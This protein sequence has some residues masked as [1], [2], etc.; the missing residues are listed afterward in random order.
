MKARFLYW[1]VA[2][3][4]LLITIGE[5]GFFTDVEGMVVGRKTFRM[6]GLPTSRRLVIKYEEPMEKEPER[7]VVRYER[8]P[9]TYSIYKRFKKG[10]KIEHYKFSFVFFRNDESVS[11]SWD[12]R[13]T[14]S[15]IILTFLFFAAFQYGRPQPIRYS[16]Y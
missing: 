14:V 13:W 7:L 8:I 15:I 12:T 4:F 10:D 5:A 11:F 9:V 3:L 1:V 2:I 6:W 16:R